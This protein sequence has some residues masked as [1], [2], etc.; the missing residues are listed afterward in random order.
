M[1]IAGADEDSLRRLVIGDLATNLPR[2]RRQC[3]RATAYAGLRR[4]QGRGHRGRRIS[5]LTCRRA[6]GICRR[7]RDEA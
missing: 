2:P 5:W 1:S 3:G 4:P 6:G 7:M